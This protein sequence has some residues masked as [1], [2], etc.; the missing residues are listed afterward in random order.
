MIEKFWWK[1][2]IEPQRNRSCSARYDFPEAAI[3]GE[4][5][6]IKE[7]MIMMPYQGEWVQQF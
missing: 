5:I 2:A 1:G 3:P 4:I 6:P 7:F